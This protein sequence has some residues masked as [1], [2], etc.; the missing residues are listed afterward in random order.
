MRSTE[1]GDSTLSSGYSSIVPQNPDDPLAGCTP[2]ARLK[3]KLRR[4]LRLQVAGGLDLVSQIQAERGL[5]GPASVAP[6]RDPLS[7]ETSVASSRNVPSVGKS[8]PV[9]S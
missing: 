2:V 8:P 6:L 1:E 3:D 7:G 9:E 5:P 4:S